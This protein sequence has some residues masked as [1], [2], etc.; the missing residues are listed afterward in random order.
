MSANCSATVY[1]IEFQVVAAGGG[2][3]STSGMALLAG[4][5]FSDGVPV[6]DIYARS[7]TAQKLIV[8]R[9]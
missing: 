1:D 5:S 2:A 3:P 8:W 9:A 6:G 4:D 7:A